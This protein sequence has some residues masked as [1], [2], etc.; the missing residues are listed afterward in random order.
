MTDCINCYYYK[1]LN[2]ANYD[3]NE[4]CCYNKKMVVEYGQPVKEDNVCGGDKWSDWLIG[5]SFH[6]GDT[7]MHDSV[8]NCK[9]YDEDLTFKLDKMNL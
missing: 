3:G 9:N 5:E 2:I 1:K 6:N 7:K 8:G 4:H